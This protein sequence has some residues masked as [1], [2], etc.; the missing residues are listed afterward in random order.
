MTR[1]SPIYK[2]DIGQVNSDYGAVRLTLRLTHKSPT[3]PSMRPGRDG[4]DKVFL[5]NNL[6]SK[7]TGGY[8]PKPKLSYDE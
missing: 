4:Q 3:R 7:K 1:R 6:T 8:V 2:N 5:Q